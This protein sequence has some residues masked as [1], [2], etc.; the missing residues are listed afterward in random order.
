MIDETLDQ[1]RDQIEDIQQK[2]QLFD[3]LTNLVNS[4]IMHRRATGLASLG[5]A[6]M[7]GFLYYVVNAVSLALGKAGLFPPLLAVSLS[8]IIFLSLGLLFIRK[9]S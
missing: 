4:M 6:I 1:L 5:I 9:L 3:E 8:H 7:V 2:A